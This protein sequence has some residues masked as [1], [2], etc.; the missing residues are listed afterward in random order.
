[1]AFVWNISLASQPFYKHK[2][3]STSVTTSTKRVNHSLVN[4]ILKRSQF[5]G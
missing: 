1:M 2:Q 5:E 4:T 3:H